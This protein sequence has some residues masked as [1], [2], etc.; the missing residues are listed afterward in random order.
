MATFTQ[1]TPEEIDAAVKQALQRMPWANRAQLVN[2]ALARYLKMPPTMRY[3][4]TAPQRMSD[5]AALGLLAEDDATFLARAMAED[6]RQI[7]IVSDRADYASMVAAAMLNEYRSARS[8]PVRSMVLCDEP[9]VY[10]DGPPLIEVALSKMEAAEAQSRILSAFASQVEG[11]DDAKRRLMYLI[12][13]DS[14]WTNLIL[15]DHEVHRNLRTA[16]HVGMSSV[17]TV[18]AD[19]DE[20]LLV[21]MFAIVRIDAR[22]RCRVQGPDERSGNL[23]ARVRAI[24]AR[25]AHEALPELR[26]HV[27]E[28]WSR[29]VS[30]GIT[31]D[32]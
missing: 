3:L 17:W 24:C 20:R 11:E 2:E 7:A 32:G 31:R 25:V 22:G 9:T 21:N 26:R 4:Y 1:R 29:H 5:L 14:F 18:R 28:D 8:A 6:G 13:V 16:R 27:T 19:I 30:W 10:A 15:L 23:S 12:V